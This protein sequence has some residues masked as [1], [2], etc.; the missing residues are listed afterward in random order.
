MERKD[1]FGI[2]DE[3]FPVSKNGLREIDPDCFQ[4]KDRINC[5]KEAV[6]TKEGIKMR[7]EV[8]DR[9]PG[10]GFMNR[11]KRWSSMKELNRLAEQKNKRKR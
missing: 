9:S 1:C 11:L 5:L 4:C 6:S 10:H 3:V 7:S 8:L 2:L